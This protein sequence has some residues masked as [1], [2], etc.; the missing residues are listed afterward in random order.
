MNGVDT[1]VERVV[2]FERERNVA[3]K[4]GTPIGDAVKDAIET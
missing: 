3:R 4:T 1:I 2:V